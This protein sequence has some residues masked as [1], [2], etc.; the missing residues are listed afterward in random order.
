[1]RSRRASLI[2]RPVQGDL[3]SG[4]AFLRL[5][6]QEVNWDGTD[7]GHGR[8]ESRQLSLSAS[9][10]ATRGM[11]RQIELEDDGTDAVRLVSGL[12]AA[13]PGLATG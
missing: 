5:Q 7:K 2:L 9:G 3:P 11:T 4:V 13:P 10:K 8:L 1:M 6:A 12:A